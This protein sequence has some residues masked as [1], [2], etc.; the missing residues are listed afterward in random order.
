[1]KLDD[2][3]LGLNGS[4][5]VDAVS[6][7]MIA[8]DEVLVRASVC[9]PAELYCIAGFLQ[10]ELLDRAMT[11]QSMSTIQCEESVRMIVELLNLDKGGRT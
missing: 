10:A 11:L 1:M 6:A 7:A 3:S 9:S 8:I 2:E 4:L 5:I